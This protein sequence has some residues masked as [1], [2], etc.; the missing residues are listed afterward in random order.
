MLCLLL[1]D[2]WRLHHTSYTF[3]SRHADTHSLPHTITHNSDPVIA[4]VM[5]GSFTVALITQ[6]SI[7]QRPIG[8]LLLF[9]ALSLSCQFINMCFLFSPLHALLSVSLSIKCFILA[10]HIY[11]PLSAL[12]FLLFTHFAAFINWAHNKEMKKQNNMRLTRKRRHKQKTHANKKNN[13]L[14]FHSHFLFI[15]VFL[16]FFFL[17]SFLHLFHRP[18]WCTEIHDPCTVYTYILTKKLPPA[19]NQMLV[20]LHTVA[21][22]HVGSQPACI[23]MVYCFKWLD[24]CW[25]KSACKTIWIHLLLWPVQS[26]PVPRLPP[27]GPE[28]W[29]SLRSGG[30]M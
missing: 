4:L 14:Q 10:L 27:T 8:F 29:I 17:L 16:H 23:S 30:V 12:Q 7:S 26:Y 13:Y 19:A 22:S 3:I 2:A 5:A 28:R 15:P 1:G 21:D 24:C 20:N 25:I 6:W 9:L 11:F 18:T